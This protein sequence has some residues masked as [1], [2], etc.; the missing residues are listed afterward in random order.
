MAP[1]TKPDLARPARRW[2]WVR[3][4]LAA[5]L[6]L[7]GVLVLAVI[8]GWVWLQSPAGNRW[9][10]GKVEGAVAGV[11]EP[12]ASFEL[13]TLETNLVSRIGLDDVRFVDASGHEV[14]AAESITLRYGLIGLLRRHLN[15][16]SVAI[17]G[18]S[19][20]FVV[21]ADGV[22]SLHRLLGPPDPAAPPGAPWSGLPIDVTVGRIDVSRSSLRFSSPTQ[23]IAVVDLTIGG[24]ARVAGKRVAVEGLALSGLLAEPEHGPIALGGELSWDGDRADLVG[25]EVQALGSRVAVDGSV[26][27][28]TADVDLDVAVGL[29]PLDLSGL[30][31]LL[32][33]VG[34]AGRWRGGLEARGPLN[35]VRV[36][37]SLDGTEGSRGG[38]G[39]DG[40][41]DLTGEI[42]WEAVLTPRALH[43]EDLYTPLAEMVPTLGRVLRLDGRLEARGG[44]TEWPEGVHADARFVGGSQHIYGMDFDALELD[45]RLGNG[46]LALSALKTRGPLG[47]L[48]GG[49]TIDLARGPLDLQLEGSFVASELRRFGAEGFGGSGWLRMRLRGNT[50]TKPPTIRVSGA[51]RVADLTYMDGDVAVSAAS[52]DVR[53]D[54]GASTVRV[55]VDVTATDALVYGV[56]IDRVDDPTIAVTYHYDGR[57]EVEGS[58]TAEGLSMP[59]VLSAASA[60]GPWSF[61]MGTDK[62]QRLDAELEIG[63]F[64]LLD[65]TG[66]TDGLARIALDDDLLTF[67]V[68]LLDDQR[69]VLDTEGTFHLVAQDL[70]LRRLSFSP[71]PEY[72]YTASRAVRLRLTPEGGI[73]DADVS[74][75]G[76]G[77]ERI[78]VQGRLG[79]RGPLDATVALTAFDLGILAALFPES[80]GDVSGAL[81]LDARLGGRGEQL[82]A[83]GSVGLT[84]TFLAEQ[85]APLGVTGTFRAAAGVLAVEI[86]STVAGAPLADLHGTLPARL[87]LSD[88][89][90]EIDGDVDLVLDLRAGS[91]ERLREVAGIQVPSGVASGRL[92]ARGALRDPVLHVVAVTEARLDTW[93]EPVRVELGA[94]REDGVITLWTDAYEGFA[95]RAAMNG[96]AT[97]ALPAVIAWGLGHGAAPPG[98]GLSAYVQSLAVDA[99]LTGFPV[100]SALA[101]I[102]QPIDAEGRLIGDVSVRGSPDT[103]IL[104]G[105][106]AWIDGRLGDIPVERGVV[107]LEPTDDGYDVEVTLLAEDGEMRLA[108]A[109]PFHLDL[110]KDPLSWIT[111]TLALGFHARELP[112]GLI[113]A[114]L[115]DVRDARGVLFAEG[116]IEG[117]V[118]DPK[119][120]I[121]IAIRD[122]ELAYLPVG[123]RYT[124]IQFS[125]VVTADRARIGRLTLETEPIRPTAAMAR[126]T[127]AVGGERRGPHLDFSG[128]VALSDW[129]PAAMEATVRLQG[130]WVT[131]VSDQLIRVGGALDVAGA[132]PALSITGKTEVSSGYV[133]LDATTFLEQGDLVLDPRIAVHR[134][135]IPL[136]PKPPDVE[137]PL[138]H[139]FDVAV[140][141]ELSR[142]F[143]LAVIFPFLTS[144]GSVGAALTTANMSARLGG[145]LDLTMRR[146]ELRLLGDVDVVDGRVAVLRSKFTLRGGVV[147]FQGDPSSPFLDVTARMDVGSTYLEMRVEGTPSSPA[148]AFSSPDY[149]S[150]TQV[151][152]M[153]VTGQEPQDLS[154]EQGMSATQMIT[155]LL[156]TSVLGGAKIGTVAFDADGTVRIG[157]PLGRAYAEAV[158]R[159]N[160][161]LD[162]N[163]Y[164]MDVEVQVHRRVVLDAVLGD[165]KSWLDLFWEL[166]F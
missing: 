105:E 62:S 22:T 145:E 153:L 146:G 104:S 19:V 106:M 133:K 159:L 132:W 142:N 127:S 49:G 123:V 126:G 17:D 7:L 93:T 42:A 24:T 118:L 36:R 23:T 71:A 11:L 20:D 31:A 150:D 37:A 154:P 52:A 47:L 129:A 131:A 60:T 122:A 67:G 69:S 79:V 156:L 8:V 45:A 120:A 14:L 103:P 48:D 137:P 6:G 115:P 88:P 84:G 10:Q 21:D 77:A 113:E 41:A 39:L 124:D 98:A 102:G 65:V 157:I 96:T 138:W 83:E 51:V 94:H 63:A 38:L 166:R 54:V 34:L 74:L 82:E 68:D 27:G 33:G 72:R 5:L 53:V 46:V 44:G 95:R 58:A 152:T 158:Y 119:P 111:G 143:E 3:R 162:E 15:V 161:K 130:F 155:N 89:G 86:A 135:D 50:Q 147:R 85:E 114:F 100:S 81:D 35:A 29:D 141:V 121:A 107:A 117:T 128:E 163:H 57:V 2:A 134:G 30:D 116:I 136:L 144:F 73:A 99:R 1:P 61:A 32:G 91:L 12:G 13:G 139:A 66:G 108:G 109:V 70:D 75:I 40:T 64:T 80:L 151:M 92:T 26:R 101:L 78:T 140:G 125:A 59:G 110:R 149:S 9:L 112:V 55:D 76:R 165:R 97:D 18:L 16:Q 160:P 148:I 25:V 43:L 4:I 90:L 56:A 28:L 87:D 164:A